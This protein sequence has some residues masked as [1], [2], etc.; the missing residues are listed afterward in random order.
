[1]AEGMNVITEF[2]M[3]Y[4]WSKFFS[5]GQKF[6]HLPHCRLRRAREHGFGRLRL[7][8]KLKCLG[9]E[10]RSWADVTYRP[11]VSY[12]K[13]HWKHLSSLGSRRCIFMIHLHNLGFHVQSPRTVVHLVN[14]FNGKRTRQC[15]GL[16]CVFKGFDVK[17]FFTHIPRDVM[18]TIVDKCVEKTR[19]MY[20]GM[21][22]SEYPRVL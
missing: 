3:N 17:D 9:P 16:S 15:P 10:L 22:F 14:W 11:L 12:Y 8:P 4:M 18:L 7:W 6:G 21:D 20:P 2:I 13:H 1:M 19:E 5:W